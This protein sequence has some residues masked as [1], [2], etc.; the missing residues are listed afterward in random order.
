MKERQTMTRAAHYARY[1]SDSQREASIEDQ[2]RLTMRMVGVLRLSINAIQM[3]REASGS[4]GL[5]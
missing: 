4:A 1:S 5:S 3:M 2:F